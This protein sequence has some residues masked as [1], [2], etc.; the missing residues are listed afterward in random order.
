VT[1]IA[2]TQPLPR[3]ERL[4][5]RLRERG[6]E[7]ASLPMRRLVSM[8][9]EP[10]AVR[11]LSRLAQFDWVVFVSPGAIDITLNAMIA[12]A[13]EWPLATGIGLIGPGSAEALA[14][15]PAL[16]AGLRIVRPETAPFDADALLRCPPFEAP[17][18]LNLLVLAGTLGRHDWLQTLRERGAHVQ[19]LAV[20][21]SESL[22]PDPAGL[23]TVTQWAHGGLP[24]VFSFTVLDAVER[25]DQVFEIRQITA[26]AHQQLALAPHPRIVDALRQRGWSRARLVEPGEHALVAAIESV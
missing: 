9:D 26:W 18:G 2:L 13:M 14:Q 24:A 23:S 10:E 20:Y 19:R 17:A 3:A 21:R 22:N 6:H 5:S 1:R 25:L 11:A 4:A 12:R 15:Y 16:P 8:A 7:V